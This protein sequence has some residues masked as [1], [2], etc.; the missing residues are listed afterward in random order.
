MSSGWFETVAVA[1]RRAKKQLP[2]SV[3]WA[4]V[5][6]SENG[7][8]LNDYVAA[9]GELEFTPHAAGLPGQCDQ[10]ITVMGRPCRL[11]PGSRPAMLIA[12]RR[13]WAKGFSSQLSR[14]SRS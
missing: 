3:Y 13:P 10:A 8:T 12:A 1:Q 11:I 9:F 4:V 6:G 7:A 5:A 14:R 2:E